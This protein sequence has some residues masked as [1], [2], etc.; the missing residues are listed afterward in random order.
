MICYIFCNCHWIWSS[1]AMRCAS[2]CAP[3]LY[4]AILFYFEWC[5]F[6]FTWLSSFACRTVSWSMEDMSGMPRRSQDSIAC[7]RMEIQKA[8]H[9]NFTGQGKRENCSTSAPKILWCS[10][11]CSRFRWFR[12][13]FNYIF[14]VT[15]A[16]RRAYR[17]LQKGWQKIRSGQRPWRV[18]LLITVSFWIDPTAWACDSIKI[19]S[20]I[21]KW[22]WHRLQPRNLHC[23][24][25]RNLHRLQP[26][27]L[28][29]WKPS[30]NH[31]HPHHHHHHHFHVFSFFIINIID[32]NDRNMSVLNRRFIRFSRYV[33]KAALV[34]CKIFKGLRLTAGRRQRNGRT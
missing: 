16:P 12:A 6:F 9:C 15:A 24:Q 33:D 25:P 1:L 2:R 20:I 14:H 10:I 19:W 22:S 17:K 11:L 8:P 3:N 18:C 29:R 23:L 5:L 13:L 26:R 30:W 34:A 7:H 28:H 27:N 4:C 31:H 21:C 32:I